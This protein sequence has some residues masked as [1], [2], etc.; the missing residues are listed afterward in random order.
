M[1][2]DKTTLE[3]MLRY[4]LRVAIMAEIQQRRSIALK[5][6][7]QLTTMLMLT[8]SYGSVLTRSVSR[9]INSTMQ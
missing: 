9:Y 2:T 8:K 7:A 3:R 4:H 6:W 5:L 1:A